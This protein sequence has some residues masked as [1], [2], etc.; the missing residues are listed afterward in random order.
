MV[1]GQ[2]AVGPPPINWKKTRLSED[3]L[4][5]F[6]YILL[7]KLG[8][9]GVSIHATWK[10]V[11]GQACVHGRG[12]RGCLAPPLEMGKKDAAR[13]NYNLSPILY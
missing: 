4:I 7:M 10:G 2:G 8:G 11:G 3:I 12:G 13:R 9:G 6:T 5:S 1:G